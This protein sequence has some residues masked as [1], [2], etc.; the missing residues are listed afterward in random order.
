M[1]QHVSIVFDRAE[2]LLK[3]LELEWWWYY[4]TMTYLYIYI[5]IYLADILIYVVYMYYIL[6]VFFVLFTLRPAAQHSSL[7]LAAFFIQL[8]CRTHSIWVFPRFSL[9]NQ[10][11]LIVQS[12]WAG[13]KVKCCLRHISCKKLIVLLK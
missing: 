11:A 5:Y 3:S 1:S 2:R 4:I 8:A 7:R 13:C 10:L 6:W 9:L 12:W